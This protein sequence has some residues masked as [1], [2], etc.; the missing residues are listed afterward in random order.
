[1]SGTLL[2]AENAYF[3]SR[4]VLRDALEE[5]NK[6]RAELR[7]LVETTRAAETKLGVATGKVCRAASKMREA[8]E[9]FGPLA[10]DEAVGILGHRSPKEPKE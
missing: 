8:A 6:L 9:K 4:R 5:E 3:E 2:E 1:M 10:S 7:E